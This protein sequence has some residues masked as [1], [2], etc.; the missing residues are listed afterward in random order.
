MGYNLS[1]GVLDVTADE[2]IKIADDWVGKQRLPVP[3][4]PADKDPEFVYPTDPADLTSIELG[5]WMARCNGYYVYAVRTLG[6]IESKL[7]AVEAEYRLRINAGRQEAVE[8]IGGRPAAEVVE[9]EVLRHSEGITPLYKRRLQL[10]AIK[11]QLE[12]R[13]RIY[14]KSFQGLSRELSR[15]EMEARITPG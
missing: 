12:A 8:R 13:A 14:E 10:L 1:M 4:R 9:A 6:T 2:I 11:A 5:Q 15:R 7:I 3:T